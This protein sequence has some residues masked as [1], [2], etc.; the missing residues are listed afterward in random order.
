M[1]QNCTAFDISASSWL[2]V[3]ETQ[4]SRFLLGAAVALGIAMF[5]VAVPKTA[6]VQEYAW[7]LSEEGALESALQ[8]IA[9]L[10]RDA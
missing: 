8:H 5:A 10:R 4:T 2:T 7:C 3:M 6:Q 1:S 9:S